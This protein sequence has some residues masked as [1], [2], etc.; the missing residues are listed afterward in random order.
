MTRAP[1]PPG[2]LRQLSWIALLA[3]TA[4]PPLHARPEPAARPAALPDAAVVGRYLL[5]SN[6]WVNLHQ[7]LLHEARFGTPPPAALAGE[8]LARWQQAAGE[9]RA[10]VGNRHPLFDRELIALNAALSETAGPELPAGLPPPAAAALKAAMPLYRA[11]QWEEDDRVNRFWIALAERLLA[12]AAEELAEAHAKVYGVPFPTR[13]R[14]DVTSFGGQFGAYTVGEGESAHAVIAST[15]PGCQGF[16]AL[17]CLMHEPS[18]AIVG[19]ETGAIGTD[20]VRL[21]KELGVRPPWN[22]WHA[23][24]F[25]TS[26]ELTRRAFARRGVQGYQPYMLGMYEGPFRGLRQPLETHW[27]ACLD[28]KLS[29]A[30]A[31]RRILAET[32]P[33]KE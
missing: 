33:K 30:E 6:A 16:A 1:N 11:A 32:A 25:Y 4:G 12:A 9:Y 29:R 24:L 28:G 21:G 20:V 15:D 5:Q 13:I 17:E 23:I 22:L 26:G 7:R 19:A 31:I 8:E 2:T 14:V 27:Q 10:Y 3:L 18:H